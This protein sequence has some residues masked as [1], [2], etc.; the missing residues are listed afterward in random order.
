MDTS[1]LKTLEL[2]FKAVSADL[3]F[4]ETPEDANA[5][6]RELYELAKSVRKAIERRDVAAQIV[7][8][9]DEQMVKYLDGIIGVVEA[10]SYEQHMLWV[11]YSEE[12]SK[13][14][15]RPDAR[16]FPWQSTGHGYGETV[17]HFG[18][19]PVHV[20]LMTVTVDGHK[21]LMFDVT[22]TV[23]NHDMVRAWLDKNMP[24]SARQP[25][26]GRVNRVDAQN[27]H[28]IFHYVRH[29]A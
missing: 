9:A 17:G 26:D 4:L 7:T 28:N 19:M 15:G 16:R 10:N 6:R 27:F 22:S 24:A 18:D 8:S 14:G 25:D 13:Y 21:I 5:A 20:G 29:P 23:V 11:E 2:R 12:G 1:D 3:E